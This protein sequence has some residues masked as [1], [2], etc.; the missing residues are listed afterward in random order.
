MSA[1]SGTRRRTVARRAAALRGEIERLNHAYHTLDAPLAS[2]AEYDALFRELQALEAAHPDLQTADSPT[3]RVGGCAAH[4][5]PTVEH[6]VPMLSLG[7][8]FSDDGIVA[9]DSRA[10]RAKALAA[11]QARATASRATR[12]N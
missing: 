11:S 9:F 12:S 10:M 4:D 7:N 8:A 2:D 5:L 3:R 1:A 6:D